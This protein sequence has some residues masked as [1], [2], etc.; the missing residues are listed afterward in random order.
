MA[1]NVVLDAG[2]GGDTVAADEIAA[3]KYQ[4]VK[5][6]EGADGVNDGDISSANPLPV[7]VS[8]NATRDNG[9]IDIAAFD[10]AL[11]TGTNTLGSIANITTS[12]TPGTGAAELGKA[13]DAAHGSGDTGVFILGVRRDANTTFVSADGDYTPLAVDANGA[14]K[15]EI[16]D[17]GDSHTIDGTVTANLSATDNAVLDSIDAAVNGTLTVSGTVT[18]NLSATDNAVLD[19]IQTA[20]ELIDNAISGTEMQVDVVAPLPAGTNAIGK[21]AANSGVDIG[22]VDV[23]SISAGTNLIGDVGLGVRTSGGATPY[24]NDGTQTETQ[25]KGSGGQIYCIVATNTSASARYLQLFNNVAASVTPGTT[26]PTNE[27][28]IPTQGD[29]NG[30]GIVIPLPVPL[31]YGTG[32]TFFISTTQ[33]GATA[34]TANDV[35]LNIGYA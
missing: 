28:Y 7:D 27:F 8:D 34:A 9:K 15:V 32:I 10:A 35:L 3:V 4:R 13:E 16:F 25:I 30:A 22:D 17:G 11:P 31:A 6:V 29:T 26:T 19:N 5:I 12:I 2:S 24:Y 1:E 18:A 23:T 20:V 33:G 21:L 14:L